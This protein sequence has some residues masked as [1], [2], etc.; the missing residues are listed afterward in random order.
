MT[1][2]FGFIAEVYG[3]NIMFK[4]ASIIIFIG[5]LLLYIHEKRTIR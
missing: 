4:S 5:T 1:F 2:F 3:F